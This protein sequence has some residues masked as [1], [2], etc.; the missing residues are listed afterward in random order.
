[1]GCVIPFFPICLGLYLSFKKK[2]SKTCRKQSKNQTVSRNG[3]PR[4]TEDPEFYVGYLIF[5]EDTQGGSV[6]GKGSSYQCG[7]GRNVS[8][9]TVSERSPERGNGNPLQYSCLENPMDRGAWQATIHGVI[10]EPDMT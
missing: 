2:I 7:L 10:E 3:K 9:I 1:M 8:S 5:W 6:V 4:V